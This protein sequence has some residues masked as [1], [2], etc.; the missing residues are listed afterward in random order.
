MSTTQPGAD[1]T[2]SSVPSS[3]SATQSHKVSVPHFAMPVVLTNSSH[4]NHLMAFQKQAG[5]TTGTLNGQSITSNGGEH[6]KANTSK[7]M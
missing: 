3:S 2:T 1:A 6:K 5:A 4:S 7:L